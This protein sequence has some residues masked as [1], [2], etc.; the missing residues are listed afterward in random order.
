MRPIFQKSSKLWPH[1]IW[2]A[3]AVGYAF[4]FPT[5]NMSFLIWIIFVPV[6][7]FAYR[8]PYNKT[9]FYSF[10]Y[11]LLFWVMTLFWLMAFHE[12]SLPFLVPAYSLYNAFFFFC[13]AFVAKKLP[14]LRVFALPVFWVA[15]ELLRSTGYVGFQWNLIGD[16]QWQSLYVLQSADIWGVYGVSFLI[17]LVNSVLAEV[18]HS[19][20]ETKKLGEAIVKH[21]ALLI[22]VGAVMAANLVYGIITYH[23]YDDIAKKSEQAKIALMQPNT[24]SFDDWWGT[25]GETYGKLWTLNAEAA[26]KDPDIIV[27]SETMLRNSVWVYMQ[28]YGADAEINRFNMRFISMPFEFDT[29]ILFAHPE[30]G[31]DGH[32]YNSVD[33][34]DPRIPGYKT[35]CKIHLTPFGEW[36][37]YYYLIPPLKTMIESLGAASYAPAKDFV[38]F[39]GR[40]GKFAVMI[41]FEDIFSILARKFIL[42]GVN[43]FLNSTN[44]GWAYRFQIGGPFPL[45]Q[46]IA[47]VAGV[48]IAVRRPIARAVN[49]GVSG[50]VM[51]NGSMD[52]SPVPIYQQGFYV[53]DVPVI[54][55]Q[56]VTLY[57]RFGYLFPYIVAILAL[58]GM[59]FAVFGVKHEPGKEN[60]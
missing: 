48:A 2:L 13:I 30:K 50:V 25:M 24:G 19:W 36:L 12:I 46:H 53:A 14:K 10:F 1:V 59:A 4:C 42:K 51:P 52:I 43:Y 44:D 60:V 28:Q 47:G 17:L 23:Y 57:V 55:E 29:P 18:I 41:C 31:T 21:R 5:Y 39:A 27:W 11:S 45:W 16:T 35:Y 38:I 3:W 34:I 9:V 58:A 20:I 8:Q 26:L 32:N 40:K 54:D 22:V 15:N 7:V 6:L 56:I 33:Y 49:T 37:P